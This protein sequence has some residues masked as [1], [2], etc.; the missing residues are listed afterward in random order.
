ML[1]SLKRKRDIVGQRLVQ[2]PVVQHEFVVNVDAISAAVFSRCM[3]EDVVTA[4][5]L[6]KV[7]AG[8]S[9]RS[10]LRGQYH[11]RAL[12][13]VHPAFCATHRWWPLQLRIVEVLGV[14]TGLPIG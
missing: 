14:E 3:D 5:S 6:G 12:T 8:P 1:A 9:G 11:P 4:R 10:C 2:R 13:E 7:I